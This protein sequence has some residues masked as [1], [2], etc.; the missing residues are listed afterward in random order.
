[1]SFQEKLKLYILMKLWLLK[2]ENECKKE[3]KK[4]I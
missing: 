3:A 2:L 4:E 1:M